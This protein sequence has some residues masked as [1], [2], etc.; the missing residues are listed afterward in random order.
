MRE[1]IP[2]LLTA[3]IALLC[4]GQ[5]SDECRPEIPRLD[6]D[7]YLR[8]VSLDLR[9]VSATVE[10]HES[11]AIG[12]GVPDALVDEWL[13]SEEFAA[14]AVRRHRSLLWPAID[15]VRLVHFRRR[16]STTGSATDGS[17]RYYRTGIARDIRVGNVPCAN[18]AAT[19][20]SSGRPVFTVDTVTGNRVEGWVEVEPYWAPGTTIKVCAADA[21][22][23]AVSGSGR[24]CSSRES[25]SDPDCGCGPD[26]AWCDTGTTH[27][28]MVDAFEQDV[29][30][31][32]AAHF[33]ADE[34]YEAIFTS[35]R[36]R[37]RK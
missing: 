14:R 23:V 31:R 1:R 2:I 3:T 36:A 11:I 29:E 26:L 22:E 13:A 15:N 30:R 12:T 28:A 35:S 4:M 17:L 6:R 33:M 37:L 32:L 27:T 20:D 34:P 16:L 10:E 7:A 25:V 5:S 8:V 21:R 19:F 24:D 9:G 18:R